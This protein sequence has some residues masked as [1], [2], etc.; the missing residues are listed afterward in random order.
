[1]REALQPE[2]TDYN[3]ALGCISK[4]KQL[5]RTFDIIENIETLHRMNDLI[6]GWKVLVNILQNY[7]S[8]FQKTGMQL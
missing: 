8:P 4:P 1:M 2:I 6:L 3:H 7:E 5:G